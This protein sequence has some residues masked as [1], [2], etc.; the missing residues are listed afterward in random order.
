M[1]GNGP[2]NRD[3]DPRPG[4]SGAMGDGDGYDYAGNRGAYEANGRMDDRGNR[5]RRA[6]SVSPGR[7]GKFRFVEA[8]DEPNEAQRQVA[9]RE[10]DRRVDLDNKQR[11]TSPRLHP[12]QATGSNAHDGSSPEGPTAR[13]QQVGDENPTARS[14]W[15]DEKEALLCTLWEDEEHLYNASMDDHRRVD[16][17]REAIRRIAARLG[18]EGAYTRY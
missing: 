18:M 7:G 1:T 12:V 11:R 16:R 15:T 14:R 10:Q 9:R 5:N 4:N 6:A 2:R 13:F 8:A 17:R 3:V